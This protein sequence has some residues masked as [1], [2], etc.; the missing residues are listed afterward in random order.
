MSATATTSTGKTATTR[1]TGSAK[2]NNN[3]NNNKSAVRRAVSH[4]VS[5][6][7]FHAT[8][9]SENTPLVLAV[10]VLVGAVSAHVLKNDPER[11][12][13][14]FVMFFLGGCF[15]VFLAE[16]VLAWAHSNLED[17]MLVEGAPFSAAQVL[18]AES[19][20]AQAGETPPAPLS[21]ALSVSAKPV[22]FKVR[23]AQDQ[24]VKQ[25]YDMF[26]NP[27]TAPPETLAKTKH[28][29]VAG[30][31]RA[32]AERALTARQFKVDQ[33]VKLIQNQLAWREREG[34]DDI[35]N[36]Q[37][38][39]EHVDRIRRSMC[40]GF[41]GVDKEGFPVL[42]S[43]MGKLS[44]S[45]LKDEVGMPNLMTYHI[46]LMEY[47]ARVYFP[48]VSEKVGRTV[49]QIT[50][51]VDL[52]GFG[53]QTVSG[54]FWSVS[55]AVGAVD[56]D[57][58]FESVHKVLIVNAPS[59]FRFFWRTAAPLFSPETRAKFVMLDSPADLKDHID[60]AQIP[61]A[62]GG[63]FTGPAVSSASGPFP[64]HL[65]AMDAYLKQVRG[66]GA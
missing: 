58:Y 1:S 44:M 41:C 35:F 48:K 66:G 19:I 17:P 43:Q 64:E 26:Y 52:S 34:V 33:T 28:T 31:G 22:S 23:S 54:D 12:E 6:V 46:Q 63:E 8:H 15:M 38:P 65:L 39:Q 29:V 42:W 55:Q 5:I 60:A 20:L 25:I 37:V 36:K 27:E 4:V 59:F 61:A 32:A 45:K 10:G 47:N 30:D 2:S 9:P 14:S 13:K 16:R 53:I 7:S 40:D 57:N 50:F 3:N 21:K 18:L 49:Y 56:A 24:A 51:V 11:L 62:F